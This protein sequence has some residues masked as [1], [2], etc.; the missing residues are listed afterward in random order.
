MLRWAAIFLLL[1]IVSAALG[2]GGIAAVAVDLARVLF[3]IFIVLFAMMMAFHLM[4]G[5][6]P[7][8]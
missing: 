2:F 4:R 7:L 6:G 1:A 8:P 5:R 3:F